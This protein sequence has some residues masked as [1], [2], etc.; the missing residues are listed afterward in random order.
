[1]ERTRSW[2]I[3]GNP[4]VFQKTHS[5]GSFT[6]RK[7]ESTKSFEKKNVFRLWESYSTRLKTNSAQNPRFEFNSRESAEYAGKQYVDDEEFDSHGKVVASET[8]NASH[9]SFRLSSLKKETSTL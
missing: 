4:K 7:G 3:S 6:I 2:K 1:M 9:L 8:N 5:A